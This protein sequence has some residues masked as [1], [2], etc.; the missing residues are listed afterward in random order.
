MPPPP[1]CPSLLR[2]GT[3]T[4]NGNI[5]CKN[6]AHICKIVS[7]V[8]SAVSRAPGTWARDERSRDG[9]WE[10]RSQSHNFHVTCISVLWQR[11]GAQMRSDIWQLR[12]WVSDWGSHGTSHWW[13]LHLNTVQPSLPAAVRAPA[14][15]GHAT[16]PVSKSEFLVQ[17][18]EM[19]FI[20]VN[21]RLIF[22]M[23][24]F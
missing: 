17:V 7:G 14:Y 3:R 15:C 23:H 12:D 4:A 24:T 6:S 22:T 5:T 9:A 16:Q 2:C 20:A 8:G 18:A 13:S 21:E 10:L 19:S 11:A 1:R